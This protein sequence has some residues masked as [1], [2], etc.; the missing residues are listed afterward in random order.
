MAKVLM[1]LAAVLL[2]VGPAVAAEDT[3]VDPRQIARRCIARMNEAADDCVGRMAVTARQTIKDIERLLAAGK[4]C[5]ARLLARRQIKSIH[6]SADRCVRGI[7]VGACAC[8]KLL[9][10]LG[11]PRLAEVVAHAR[12]RAV[13]KV[14][15]VKRA[16]A[17]AI[18]AA[19][20]GGGE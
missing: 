2:L 11:A 9:H 15:N 7:R 19:L 5:A 18:R 4:P 17:R 3:D 8:I 12:D 1:S 14:R 20:P 16:A 10:R 13:D 6:D